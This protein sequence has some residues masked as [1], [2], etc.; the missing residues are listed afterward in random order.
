MS[1]R[2]GFLHTPRGRLLA[3]LTGATAFVILLTAFAL[4]RE[5]R[6]SAP[7]F[8][9][10]PVF[11]NLAVQLADAA[12]VSIVSK[13]GTIDIVRS[14]DVKT[15]HW[16]IPAAHGYRADAEHLRR[17]FLGLA[18][19]EAIEK[20]T[21]RP[22]WHAALALD[23]PKTGGSA[24][25]VT[26]KDSKGAP[27]AALLVGKLKPGA[28]GSR[29]MSYVRRAGENQTYLA[30]GDLPLETE[31]RDWLDPTVLDIARGR[32][33][34]V[35]VAPQGSAGYSLSRAKPEDVNF[36]L[37]ALPEGRQ[38][39]SA[40]AA[41]ATGAAAVDLTLDDVRPQG[42]LDFGKAS[43][44]AF[45]TFDG[46]SVSIDLT[47]KDGQT[48]IR[49]SAQ[50]ATPETTKEAAT[51]EVR[52]AGWAYAVPGWKAAALRKPLDQLLKAPEKPGK[53]PKQTP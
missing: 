7:D 28:P 1:S 21:A 14:G 27:L 45:E 17:L 6:L 34:R 3:G 46:L 22:D 39:L 2:S 4:V 31:R 52:T 41:N 53:K 12:A 30:Q 48:F 40:T 10:E 38:M 23:D 16:V 32:I 42:E 18:E 9:P 20:K 51:I 15:G 47:D 26:V 36:S 19:L 25:A 13:T 44:T 29:P 11:R 5:A 35:T 8:T 49:L 33:K 50:G 37:E 24:I 43:H